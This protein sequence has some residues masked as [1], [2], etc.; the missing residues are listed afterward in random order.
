M[1]NGK[2]ASQMTITKQDAPITITP[3]QVADTYCVYEHLMVTTPGAPPSVIFVGSCKLIDVFR[4]RDARNNSYW[5]TLTSA[6]APVMIRIIM[7]A[8]DGKTARDGAVKH[9]RSLNPMPVCNVHGF[10]M[11]GSQRA[12]LCSNGQT[13]QSQSEAA[14]ALGV[15]QSAISQNLRGTLSGVKGYTFTYAERQA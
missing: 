15:T 5:T 8:Q 14:A 2:E 6:G 3:A 11:F 12:I 7:T 4:M 1:R 13:Y 10:N 9:V